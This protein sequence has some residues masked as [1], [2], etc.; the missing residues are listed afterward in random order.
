MQQADRTEYLNRIENPSLTKYAFFNTTRSAISSG[1]GNTLFNAAYSYPFLFSDTASVVSHAQLGNGA[2][3][4]ALRAPKLFTPMQSV[5]AAAVGAIFLAPSSFYL[6]N[7]GVKV[8]KDPSGEDYVRVEL[9]KHSI[10]EKSIQTGTECLVGSWLFGARG[11]KS[12]LAGAAGMLGSVIVSFWEG[13]DAA[14]NKQQVESKSN[15]A[16][17]L[18]V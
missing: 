10:V 3:N 14:V 9:K 18:K 5:A 2:V 12:P 7:R 6:R 15:S 11:I 4:H 13:D 8:D 16:A 1:L 17:K